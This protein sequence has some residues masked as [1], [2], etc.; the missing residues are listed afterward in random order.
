MSNEE[1]P[2][3]TGSV[4]EKFPSNCK[5]LLEALD[6]SPIFAM[7][8]G[9]K[10]LF[11]T[12]FLAFL[13][14]SNDGTLKVVRDALINLLFGGEIGPVVTWREK[15][16]LDLV[17]VPRSCI[18]AASIG[19]RNSRCS[20]KPIIAV[21]IEAKLKSLPDAGQLK[22]YN[23]KLGQGIDLELDGIDWG[24]GEVVTA[25]T[26]RIKLAELEAGDGGILWVPR[27][28]SQ[29]CNG[30]IRRVLLSPNGAALKDSYG[31]DN[32]SWK[33]LKET[34]NAAQDLQA[35][36]DLMRQVVNDYQNSLGN[37]LDVLEQAAKF[38]ETAVGE[39]VATF[40]VFYDAI[41]DSGFRHR[42][43]HD[44]VGKYA[45]N[46][47]E[48]HVREK[49]FAEI[50][51]GM[52]SAT[53]FTRQQPGI[54]F[55]WRVCSQDD[56]DIRLGVQIQGKQ[57]RHYVCVKGE[58]KLS[59]NQALNSTISALDVWLGQEGLSG[60]RKGREEVL[61]LHTYSNDKEDFRYTKADISGLPL[62]EL[63]EKIR[64][65]LETAKKQMSQV[66]FQ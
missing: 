30:K 2:V 23:E 44:L 38:V 51:E 32:V 47:L 21:V 29:G 43:I 22:S 9:A 20:S 52:R 58:D 17:I 4:E 61:K 26:A 35:H 12:N 6:R 54:E 8:L 34:M 53:I 18:E 37:L 5:R 41:S 31:W 60:K 7:S 57:Y 59:R 3:S 15:S 39:N 19:Q 14:E 33:S 42:R 64:N 16:N 24:N 46:L 36:T 49:L 63:A 27:K 25:S 40:G 28:K 10:E 50:D 13:L 65:S 56:K 45:S 66:T 1:R 62:S 55:E 11:H 48:R